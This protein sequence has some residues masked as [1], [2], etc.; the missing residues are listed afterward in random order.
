MPP[1]MLIVSGCA[2]DPSVAQPISTT[3]AT[4]QAASRWLEE[5]L[6]ALVHLFKARAK[7]GKGSVTLTL[8]QLHDAAKQQGVI[9][10]RGGNP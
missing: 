4:E 1:P 6:T 10:V 3:S 7:S 8:A 5:Q 9:E 2:V